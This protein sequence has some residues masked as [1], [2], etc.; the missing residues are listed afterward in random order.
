[1]YQV[2]IEY[3]LVAGTVSIS[4]HLCAAWD[5]LGIDEVEAI[6]SKGSAAEPAPVGDE[7]LPAPTEA[8]DSISRRQYL[9]AAARALEYIRAGDIYQVQLG[10]VLSVR[11][12]ASPVT[13]YARLR[14]RNPSPYCYIAPF[15]D[16]TAFGASPELFVGVDDRRVT[17]KPIAGTFPRGATGEDESGTST[18]RS[19]EKEIAEHVMLVDLCR[20]DISKI[21]E[22]KSLSVPDLMSV[23]QYSHVSHLVSTITGTLRRDCDEYDVL[24]AAFPAGTMT[25]APK[26]RA[27]EIIEELETSR[28]GIYAGAVGLIGFSGDIELA[29]C[30]RGAVHRG[31]QF[32][33]RAS[34]GVVA[35][36]D[37]DREW[38]ETFHKLAAAN[39]AITGEEVDD[40]RIA[41]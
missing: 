12:N 34:A 21:C 20:N 7:D 32:V 14:D 24:T 22:S 33:Y 38:A 40:A 3:D 35:D 18:L 29:L 4:E 8:A 25:G 23:E 9:E 27:I 10:H 31:D 37:P 1:M 15:G 6:V 13:V 41:R 19:D 5:S 11:S 39:W 26:I 36:S 2:M 28:R 30:I 16:R 17:M